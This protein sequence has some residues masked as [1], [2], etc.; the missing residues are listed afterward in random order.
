MVSRCW[1]LDASIAVAWFFTDEPLRPAALD[2]RSQLVDDPDRFF[3]PHLF[4][5]ELAHV[6]ARKSGRDADFVDRALGLVRRLGLRSLALP[7]DACAR[8][9]HWTCERGL[10]GYDATY[11]ALAESLN[12]RWITADADAARRAGV[13]DALLLTA[14]RR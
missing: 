13:H 8:L 1:V 14:R 5:S 3:V 7:D 11:V 2:V 10:T 9:G 4:F 6:L 12:G